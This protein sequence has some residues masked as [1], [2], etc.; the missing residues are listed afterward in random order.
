MR[1]EKLNVIPKLKNKEKVKGFFTFSNH[2]Q[3][4]STDQNVL[5]YDEQVIH[6]E[7][8]QALKCVESNL[9][10]ASSNGDNQRFK[11]K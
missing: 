5:T 10:F 3:I 7:I 1:M 8:F 11:L 2:V 9:S 6:A 4:L